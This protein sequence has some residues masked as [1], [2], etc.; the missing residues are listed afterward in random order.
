MNPKQLFTFC[1]FLTTLFKL[2]AQTEKG[3]T[4]DIGSPDSSEYVSAIISDENS[5]IFLAT[6]VFHKVDRKQR[7]KLNKIDS[8]GKILWTKN[9]PEKEISI[10]SIIKQPD[11]SLILAGGVGGDNGN[12][13]ANGS[14][15]LMKTDQ[16]GNMLWEKTFKFGDR[17]SIYSI[18]KSK[19]GYVLLA[20][21]YSGGLG[22]D[23]QQSTFLCKTDFEGK[24][25]WQKEFKGNGGLLVTPLNNGNYACIFENSS[26]EGAVPTQAFTLT[27]GGDMLGKIEVSDN[28]IGSIVEKENGELIY[29]TTEM[30]KNDSGKVVSKYVWAKIIQDGALKGIK[31]LS[32]GNLCGDVQFI[33]GY[34][35]LPLFED[36][37]KLLKLD[38]DFNLIDQAV[39]KLSEDVNMDCSFITPQQDM[40]IT[41]VIKK[42]GNPAFASVSKSKYNY[43]IMLKKGALAEIF[44]KK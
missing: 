13:P 16:N 5:D 36:Q 14:S 3:F 41:G 29:F 25:V 15:I 34:F 24:T 10:F 22:N 9:Y 32:N 40:I 31:K 38:S 6:I 42:P 28:G 37:R 39:I 27:P 44:K 8:K 26:N 11:A 7:L 35:Y 23:S 1:F 33:A 21:G 18:Y 2:G 4:L 30:I 12:W 19:D 17:G 20:S 43:D